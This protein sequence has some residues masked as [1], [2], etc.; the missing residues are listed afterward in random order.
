MYDNK[1]KYSVQTDLPIL[2]ATKYVFLGPLIIGWPRSVSSKNHCTEEGRS[3]S[4][5]RD[6][7][8][9]L[10]GEKASCFF[11]LISFL[12]TEIQCITYFK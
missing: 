2:S 6:D 12:P 4:Y 7:K 3:S 5:D 11:E 8:F 9:V 10:G 1:D